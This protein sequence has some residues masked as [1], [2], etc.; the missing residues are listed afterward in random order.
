MAEEMLNFDDRLRQRIGR[1]SRVES[2]AIRFTKQELE[3]LEKVAH[4]K[5]TTLREWA[6]DVLLREASDSRTGALFT[7]VV[8]TRM[9]LNLVLKSIACGEVITAEVFSN[10]LTNVR[11]TK[12]QA[13]TDVMEQYAAAG[14]KERS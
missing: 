10:I 12:H 8:A 7:E 13:A 9:L 14:Q 6:R 5:K 3:A 4:E 2:V 11:T 1:P